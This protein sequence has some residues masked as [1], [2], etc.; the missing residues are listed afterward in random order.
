MHPGRGALLCVLVGVLAAPTGTPA[1]LRPLE[2][3]P[4]EAIVGAGGWDARVGVSLLEAERASPAGVEGRL[5]EI[6]TFSATHDFGPVALRLSGTLHRIFEERERFAEPIDGTAPSD[7]G[8]RTDVGDVRVETLVSLVRDGTAEG[9][10]RLGVRLPTTDNRVGMER[11]R[12]DFWATLAGG[13]STGRLRLEGEAGVAIVGTRD[14]RREQADPLVGSLRARWLGGAV[15]PRLAFVWQVD[16]RN[17][18]DFRG[19]EDVRELRAGVRVGHTWPLEVEATA[20][21][22]DFDPDWGLSVSLGRVW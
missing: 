11:D 3:Y 5:W 21:T 19:V 10:L 8:R 18:P 20:G 13:W 16:T 12:T 22:G 4:W 1:Q 7:D 9:A 17:G 15:E 2:P 14:P 6:G